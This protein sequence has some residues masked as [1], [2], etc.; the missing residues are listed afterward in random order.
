MFSRHVGHEKSTFQDPLV[1]DIMVEKAT[2]EDKL[3]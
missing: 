2:Q 3:K 1:L